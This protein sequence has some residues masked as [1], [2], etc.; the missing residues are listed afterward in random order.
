[1]SM[2]D[3]AKNILENFDATSSQQICDV[4]NEILTNFRSEITQDYLK[5]KLESVSKASDE[6]EKK[7]LC[8]NLK[9]YLDWYLQGL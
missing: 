8:S 4:L 1:M 6:S 9:P 2:E 3:K 5:G 7:K